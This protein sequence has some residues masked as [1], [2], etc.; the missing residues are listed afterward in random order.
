MNIDKCSEETAVPRANILLDP[1]GKIISF[2][3]A[4]P[5]LWQIAELSTGVGAN[6]AEFFND[7]DRLSDI[8]EHI[9][10]SG[11][12]TGGLKAVGKNNF[13]FPVKAEFS[14]IKNNRGL[15]LYIVCKCCPED[16]RGVLQSDWSLASENWHAAIRKRTVMLVE[17]DDLVRMV[18]HSMLEDTGHNV[19]SSE[20]GLTALKISD[21][22]DGEIDALVTDILMPGMDGNELSRLLTARR[23]GLKVV[24]MSGHH[25]GLIDSAVKG[26][27]KVPFLR[28]PFPVELLTQALQGV[29]E[30]EPPA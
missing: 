23:P 13:R 30:G 2:N 1:D 6:I 17:D 20:S 7:H 29:I 24:Y 16:T 27:K 11:T 28:K 10:S 18:I 5:H 12:W 15:A 25:G 8:M 3:T 21:A 19:I 22:Y 4:F 14:L 26:G 9:L